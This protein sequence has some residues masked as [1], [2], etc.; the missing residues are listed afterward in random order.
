MEWL[1]P[2]FVFLSVALAVITLLPARKADIRARLSAYQ[3]SGP[4]TERD[5]K[6]EQPLFSRVAL[7]LIYSLAMLPAKLAPQRAYDEARRLMVQADVQIDLNVFMG[8]RAAGMVGTPLL[9]VLLMGFPTSLL[10]LGL[11]VL[12]TWFGG[13]LPINWLR[14][15]AAARQLKIQRSLPDTLD[16][17]TVSVEAGLGL[18]AALSKVVDKTRG[19]LRDEFS[20]VLQEVGLGKQRRVAM[21]DMAT[22]CDVPDL[23]TFISAI[24]QADQMG[25]GIAEVLTAQADEVRLRRRQRAEETAMK[26]PVKMLFPLLMCIFPAMMSVLLGPAI[27]RIYVG[28]I[29]T[30][31]GAF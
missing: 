15:K 23:N 26:A 8:L 16:L 5:A 9:L 19:P 2:L 1:I 4:L 12:L 27:W 29:A 20:R 30:D 22:R 28:F 7:P 14:R 6:L 17:I 21:R 13:R 11:L 3:Y 31:F 25:L 24:I 18:D 10:N